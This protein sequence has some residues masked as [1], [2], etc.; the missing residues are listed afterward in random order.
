[1]SLKEVMAIFPL[2]T[3]FL[4][5]PVVKISTNLSGL[6]II[7]GFIQK[8]LNVIEKSFP[9]TWVG[10]VKSFLFGDIIS[11]VLPWLLL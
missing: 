2:N 8:T 11:L 6:N 4:R 7:L 5:H 1:M 3:I 10:G 9:E